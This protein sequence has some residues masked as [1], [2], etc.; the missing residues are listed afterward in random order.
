[1]AKVVPARQ[2]RQR[3]ELK[4]AVSV[5]SGRSFLRSGAPYLPRLQASAW[6]IVLLSVRQPRI[7]SREEILTLIWPAAGR[8]QAQA[9][10]RRCLMQLRTDGFPIQ[11]DRSSITLIPGTVDCDAVSLTSQTASAVA[12]DRILGG[13]DHPIAREIVQ[14]VSALSSPIMP[15]QANF[16]D[17]RIVE[18]LVENDP[19]VLATFIHEQLKSGDWAY[20]HEETLK[21]CTRIL[22]SLSN[23]E[24]ATRSVL[25]LAGRMSRLLTQYSLGDRLLSQGLTASTTAADTSAVIRFTNELSFLKFETREWI[26]SE[27]LARRALKLARKT[28]IAT[29]LCEAY[30][31]VARVLWAIGKYPEAARCYL[32]SYART[33]SNGQQMRMR[34]NLMY[35]W[36]VLG[37]VVDVPGEA[38]EVDSGLPMGIGARRYCDFAYHFG[39]NE[40]AACA[41]AAAKLIEATAQGNFERYF[42]VAVDCAALA[43]AKLGR[44][45][46]AAVC[47]R[48]GT[49]IRN[50]VQHR[51]SP[52]EYDS[53]RRHL[54]GP[55]HGKEI[56]AM[57][58]SIHRPNTQEIAVEIA[59][60]LTYLQTQNIN[61]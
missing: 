42:A 51:R 31:A 47:V 28:Q 33:E 46:E 7:V 27:Q 10:L 50:E 44:D 38:V 9:Y 16:L 34:G 21:L 32:E 4:W 19:K 56:Q 58:R 49:W 1:M 41:E 55:L 25:L 54:R 13:V 29:D 35:L 17:R 45:T 12:L 22:G 30:D 52:M 59:F 53:L 8:P 43:F 23:D 20:D 39:R 57:Y 37:V 15:Q 26:A 5:L 60:R 18:Y 24:P 61:N 14:Q 40:A 3:L 36:G 2:S 48:I 6:L 11:S